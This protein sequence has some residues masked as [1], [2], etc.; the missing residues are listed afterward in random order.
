LGEEG[1]LARWGKGKEKGGR[2]PRKGSRGGGGKVVCKRKKKKKITHQ[3]ISLQ[4]GGFAGEKNKTP[5]NRKK[6]KGEKSQ[7][8]LGG[9]TGL[10]KVGGGDFRHD[11]VT[12]EK[13]TKGGGGRG[14]RR[15]N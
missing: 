14:D 6:K 11:F 10:R 4:V 3:E 1:F 13:P 15:K 12:S 5:A 7:N 9:G 8:R 2:E